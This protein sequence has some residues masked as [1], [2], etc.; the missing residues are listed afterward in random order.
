MLGTN[1][2]LDYMSS[3]PAPPKSAAVNYVVNQ[4]QNDHEFERIES[5]DIRFVAEIEYDAFGSLGSQAAWLST[6]ACLLT[7]NVRKTLR[8]KFAM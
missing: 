3:F 6:T 5:A 2:M 7:D 4:I 8:K 1:T